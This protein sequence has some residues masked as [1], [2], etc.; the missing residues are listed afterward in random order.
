ML[1]GSIESEESI[2]AD[3]Q[4]LLMRVGYAFSWRS[5]SDAVLEQLRREQ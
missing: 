5:S 4:A 3:G 1:L 2:L